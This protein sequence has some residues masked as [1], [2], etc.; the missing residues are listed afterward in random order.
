MISHKQLSSTQICNSCEIMQC[1]GGLVH[2]LYYLSQI[3]VLMLY[4]TIR[5]P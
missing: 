3:P 4:H 5:F 2:I 1:I